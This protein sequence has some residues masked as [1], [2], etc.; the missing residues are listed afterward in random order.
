MPHP[1]NAAW[2]FHSHLMRTARQIR[3]GD[4]QIIGLLLPIAAEKRERTVAAEIVTPNQGEF[5]LV[6]RTPILVTA[7]SMPGQSALTVRYIRGTFRFDEFFVEAM[8]T[9][10]K[11]RDDIVCRSTELL[12]RFHISRV[13]ARH[14]RGFD[15]GESNG[16]RATAA[17]PSHQGSTPDGRSYVSISRDP[18][19]YR[20]LGWRADEI[21]DWHSAESDAF[22]GLALSDNAVATIADVRRW[23]GSRAWYAERDIPWRYGIRLQGQPGT[24]KT[25]FIVALARDLRVPLFL[26]DLASFSNGEFF[27]AWEQARFEAPCVIAI[28]DIDAV[29][30]GRTN[31]SPRGELTFDALLNATGGAT[32]NHGVL[33]AIT[34]NRPELIDPALSKERPG[35]IEAEL[36]FAPPD[37]AG[38]LK[39]ANRILPDRSDIVAQLAQ[40]GSVGE[41]GA[42]FTDRCRRRALELFWST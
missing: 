23:Y 1:A 19:D 26:F 14:R 29:F 39:I 4:R 12:S 34:T 8:A 7:D 6:G 25:A 28:E 21:G 18:L 9:S 37:Y 11:R 41:T 36:T 3:L 15:G 20:I 33:L 17:S 35:R 32:V 10:D 31:V 2:S 22:A 5:F 30:E 38:R 40:S 16:S 42:Q 27:E 13:V 24:G